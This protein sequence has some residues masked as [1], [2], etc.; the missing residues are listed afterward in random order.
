MSRSFSLY[1][2]MHG[3]SSFLHARVLFHG[4]RANGRGRFGSVAYLRVGRRSRY[5]SPHMQG[6]AGFFAI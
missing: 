5:G 2:P 4:L 6:N 1:P 3:G